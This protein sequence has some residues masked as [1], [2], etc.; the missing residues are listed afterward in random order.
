METTT[1]IPPEKPSSIL[2]LIKGLTA[3]G[4]KFRPSDWTDRLIGA[5]SFYAREHSN[6]SSEISGCVCIIERDGV[7]GI[8]LDSKLDE[9]EPNL[10]R[11]MRNFA[12]D[13]ELTIELL[14]KSEWDQNH[15]RVVKKPQRHFI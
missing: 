4:K 11:F 13:N 1:T 12:K 15:H 8:V 6:R 9:I 3:A 5:V 2:T 10:T 14:D 7:K